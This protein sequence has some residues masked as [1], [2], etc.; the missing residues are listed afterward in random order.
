MVYEQYDS[1]VRTNSI[2][3]N[4]PSDAAIVRVKGSEK[5]LAMSTDCNAAYVHA[6][7]Y[8]GAMIAVS[9][10]VRNLVS[11]GATPVAITNCLNFGNPYNEEVYWQFVNVI[12]GMGE[13]CRKFNTPVTGGNVSFYNQ[14]SIDGKEVPVFPTPTIGMLGLLNDWRGSMT[15]G[16]VEPGDDIFMIGRLPKNVN[17]S[18][19]L[20][21]IVKIS[22]SR[23]PEFDL[24]EECIMQ[25]RFYR[26]LKMKL[27]SPFMTSAKVVC[28]QRSLNLRWY[29]IW[30]LN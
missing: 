25:T 29:T 28:G 12:K 1:M 19:Y 9:E 18:E 22:D 8:V 20:R 13:A 21:K 30:A 14:S 24:D 16:F 26:W 15:L 4:A 10:C 3:T 27:L 6:D 11:T 7:P 17:C 2:T 5:A 23:V